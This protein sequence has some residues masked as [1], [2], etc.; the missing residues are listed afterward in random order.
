LAPAEAI[1]ERLAYVADTL[2]LLKKELAG[3]KALLG[4]G[5]SPWTLATYMVEGGSSDD[6]ERIK[7]LFYTDRVLFDALLEKLTAALITYFQMQIRAGADAIQIFDSWGGIIA[8]P[9]YEAAS[10]RWIR[11]IVAAL[12]KDFP[13]ILYA[14]GTSPQL[15]DQAFSGVKVLSVDWTNDLAIVRRNLPANVAVQGNLDPVLMCTTPEIVR[16]EAGRLLESMRGTAGHI[17]NLGHG[18]TPQ[19]RLE[20]MQALVDTVTGWH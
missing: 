4:F 6:F 11:R 19:A 7:Q 18:I 20:C 15:T 16:H 8:G 12:P 10:L 2:G 1:P 13:V 3:Q 14:K 17:F 5:G 9:D